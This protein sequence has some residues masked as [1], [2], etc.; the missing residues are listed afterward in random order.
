MLRAMRA[1]VRRQRRP[2]LLWRTALTPTPSCSQRMALG[3]AMVATPLARVQE[4]EQVQ[5]REQG[6][7]KQPT[8]AHSEEELQSRKRM[9]N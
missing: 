4:Q 6:L 7:A 8:V 3:A 9:T 5:V 1:V 2:M